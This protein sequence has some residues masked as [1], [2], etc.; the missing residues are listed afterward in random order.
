MRVL[1]I[2]KIT[3]MAGVERHLLTLCQG[4]RREGVD[5]CLLLLV[6]RKLPMLDYVSECERRGIPCQRLVISHDIDPTLPLRLSRAIR[7]LQPDIAHLHLIHA[8]IYG[9]LAARFAGVQRILVSRHNQDAFRERFP[10]RGLLR[11]LWR[12]VDSAIVIAEHL[13]QELQVTEAV[14]PSKIR[15]IHY[16]L[17]PSLI[18]DK[19]DLRAELGIAPKELLVG[20]VCRLMPQKGLSDGLVAFNRGAPSNARLLI[21][22]DGPLRQSL[23]TQAAALPCHERVHFLGWRPDAAQCLADLDMLLMPSRWEGFGLVLLEAYLAGLPILASDVGGI[24]E[25]V[26]DGESGLLCPPGDIDAFARGLARLCA[27]P[28]LR[29]RL[30][31][32]GQRRFEEHFTAARMVAET[33]ALYDEQMEEMG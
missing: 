17:E 4:L 12:R 22:G 16:G 15:R 33:S 2:L 5:A 18:P 30:A 9:N 6:E 31:E 20:S 7:R 8:E 26:R 29:V 1:H 23:E 13:R 21:I 32:Q 28:E 3:R 25:V 11:L 24:A 19:P 27:E 10:L 14:P